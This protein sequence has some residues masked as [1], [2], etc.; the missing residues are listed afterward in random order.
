LRKRRDKP[1]VDGRDKVSQKWSFKN[2]P[3]GRGFEFSG[4]GEDFNS[5]LK[6]S[7]LRDILYF[8]CQAFILRYYYKILSIGKIWGKRDILGF[9]VCE[10]IWIVSLSSALWGPLLRVGGSS[11]RFMYFLFNRRLTQTDADNFFSPQ[12]SIVYK[13]V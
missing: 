12:A 2:E 8:F 4:M 7:E 10:K 9:T 5:D 6:K 3:P 1:A 13:L 11:A